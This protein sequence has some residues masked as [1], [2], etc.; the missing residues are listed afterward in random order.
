MRAAKCCRPGLDRA[1]AKLDALF[2]DPTLPRASPSDSAPANAIKTNPK[3][4]FG[5]ETRLKL[6]QE[7]NNQQ[8]IQHRCT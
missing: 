3:Y 7:F 4:T 5:D 1:R 2:T 8:G 6:A